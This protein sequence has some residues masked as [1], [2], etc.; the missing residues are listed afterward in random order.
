MM[1]KRGAKSL[2]DPLLSQHLGDWVASYP[3]AKARWYEATEVAQPPL[4]RN[5]Q[6]EAV[7]QYASVLFPAPECIGLLMDLNVHKGGLLH[8]SEFM[9]RR[10][11]AYNAGTGLPF[12]R[13][14]PPCDHFTDT[15]KELVKLLALDQPVFVADPSTSGPS[16]PL[17]S[18]TRYIQSRPPLVDTIDW[19]RPVTFRLSGDAYPC[20][21]GSWTFHGA[22]QPRRTGLNTRLPVGDWHGGMHG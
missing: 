17:Q 15:W 18:W 3:L 1:L 8:L 4:I 11:A 9:T 6:I 16:S 21:A 2:R 10:G 19:K 14:I 13:S 20:A 22:R 12:P 7:E 5:N